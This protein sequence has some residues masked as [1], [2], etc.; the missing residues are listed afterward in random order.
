MIRHVKEDKGGKVNAVVERYYGD[1]AYSDSLKD[2]LKNIVRSKGY[3]GSNGHDVAVTTPYK[4]RGYSDY[5]QSSDEDDNA[6]SYVLKERPDKD[7]MKELTQKVRK[8]E[9]LQLFYEVLKT[10]F[11]GDEILKVGRDIAKTN[12]TQ[13]QIST[14]EQL[15]NSSLK[16]VSKQEKLNRL[17]ERTTKYKM[18]EKLNKLF[19]GTKND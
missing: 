8:L 2:S 5:G 16:V 10:K 1:S 11:R 12:F 13:E 19:R 15:L 14:M 7:E 4:Y 17:Y 18:I 3:S 9:K 6:V